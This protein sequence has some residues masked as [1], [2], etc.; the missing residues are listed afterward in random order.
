VTAKDKKNR[1]V[2]A[3]I[4]SSEQLDQEEHDADWVIDYKNELET[5]LSRIRG[6]RESNAQTNVWGLAMQT[7]N[8]TSNYDGPAPSAPPP[9]ADDSEEDSDDEDPG[10]SSG[11]RRVK[12]RNKVGPDG[13]R[14]QGQ[15]TLNGFGKTMGN[16]ASAGTKIAFQAAQL[17]GSKA[18]QFLEYA[19][20]AD[21]S[22]ERARIDREIDAEAAAIKIRHRRTA[23]AM[24][25]EEG[26]KRAAE[27]AG[28]V[29][30]PVS[31][32][33]HDPEHTAK[34][35]RDIGGM[36]S[37]LLAAGERYMLNNPGNALLAEAAPVRGNKKGKKNK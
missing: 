34:V 10:P 8:P 1:S 33:E 19:A 2:T 7:I 9:P 28:H 18:L 23:L 13:E 6:K 15:G 22:R 35:W 32:T 21:G 30:T 36:G 20:D 14:L 37:N 11:P 3:D 31:L 4:D 24:I 25:D 29:D 12:G 26:V 16:V 17:G 27:W 5:K